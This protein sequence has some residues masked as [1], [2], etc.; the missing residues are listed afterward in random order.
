MIRGSDCR[1]ERLVKK[2][3]QRVVASGTSG[4]IVRAKAALSGLE[5][6][7][8][9][10]AEIFA[11]EIDNQELALEQLVDGIEVAIPSMYVRVGFPLRRSE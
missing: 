1:D 11:E 3:E 10:L 4:W 6:D 7:F 8:V 9:R 5:A 2:D